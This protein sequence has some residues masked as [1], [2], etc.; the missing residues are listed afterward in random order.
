M[1]AE[2]VWFFEQE[3]TEETEVAS[4]LVLVELTIFNRKNEHFQLDECDPLGN[5]TRLMLCPRS[6]HRRI[7]HVAIAALMKMP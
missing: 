5:A 3:I 7:I 2:S 1:L 4:G 6:P